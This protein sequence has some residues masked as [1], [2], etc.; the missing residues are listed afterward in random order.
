MSLPTNLSHSQSKSSQVVRFDKEKMLVVDPP[1]RHIMTSMR[2]RRDSSPASDEPSNGVLTTAEYVRRLRRAASL[3]T[4]AVADRAGVNEAWLERFESGELADSPNYDLVLKLV[5][6]TQP[7]RP[8]W[9]D[10]GHEHDLNLPVDAVRDREKHQ[11][12]WGKIEAVRQ[13]NRSIRRS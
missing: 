11:S 12:Y 10:S 13:V 3:S 9:W 6:A 4:R 5:A 7:P 1:R 2:T 8:D